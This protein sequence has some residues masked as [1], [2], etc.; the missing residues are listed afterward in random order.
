MI[1]DPAG[2]S[3]PALLVRLRDLHQRRES[4]V[5]R[6]EVADRS[7]QILIRDGQL[8]LPSKHPLAA[9]CTRMSA[10]GRTATR[11]EWQPLLDRIASAWS[12]EVSPRHA[13][14]ER[15][16]A[17]LPAD[18]AGPLPT[19]CLLLSAFALLADTEAPL[20]AHVLVVGRGASPPDGLAWTPAESWVLERVRHRIAAD[21]LSIGCPLSERELARTVQALLAMGFLALAGRASTAAAPDSLSRLTTTLAARISESLGARP[22]ELSAAEQR[23]EIEQRLASAGEQD[24]FEF[25][26]V[27]N[28]AR[29]E[30][31][32]AA[33]ERVARRV[34][35]D[36]ARRLGLEDQRASLLYLFER[37]VDA[38][39]TL[40]D[41][42]RKSDYRRRIGISAPSPQ[43]SAEQRHSESQDLARRQFDRARFEISNGDLHS[44][45]QLL[46]QVVR[47]DPR[48]EYWAALG[49]LQARNPAWIWRAVESYRSALA[50]DGQSAALRFALGELLERAGDLARA[51]AAYEQ[52]A[53][54]TPG[55][56][57]A[58]EALRR[59][60]GSTKDGERRA[61]GRSALG[62]LFGRE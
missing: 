42:I 21:R 8:V 30:E 12:D 60:G 15:G 9:E 17:H 50:L 23:A 52:A 2:G 10:R 24:H 35:P 28:D 54:G 31:I 61:L 7:R 6:Y 39:R 45:L 58:R 22:M 18:A 29:E 37:S 5:L 33:F 62:R 11:G 41:P 3:G 44:G 40:I 56:P 14:F 53:S 55:H 26:G 25:L 16:L 32:Q 38:F 27:A 36:Q 34:H 4:G 46:E 20:G 57:G 49:E 47:L 48:A 19:S 43:P 59:L 13:A 51:R 1:L